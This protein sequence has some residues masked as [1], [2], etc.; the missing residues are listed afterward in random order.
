MGFSVYI[1]L[2]VNMLFNNFVLMLHTVCDQE[3]LDNVLCVAYVCMYAC[4]HACMY[5][6][7]LLNWWL[8][9]FCR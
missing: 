5:V 1:V 2:I 3:K 4:M 7:I 8:Y 6:C 9:L